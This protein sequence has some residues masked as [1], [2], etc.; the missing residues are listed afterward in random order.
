M[1]T[2]VK[3]R[4]RMR[5]VVER[6]FGWLKKFRGFYQ[7]DFLLSLFTGTI[8]EQETNILRTQPNEIAQIGL[9]SL[10]P[11]IYYSAQ[12]FRALSHL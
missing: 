11:V 7:A 10:P 9:S 8:G 4:Y 12:L 2:G 6:C 1:S 3:A 5:N